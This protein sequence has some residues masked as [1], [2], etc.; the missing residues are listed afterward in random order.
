MD[1]KAK[2][3]ELVEAS[4]QDP[5]LFLVEIV[6]SN[7]NFS[8]ISII[9]DGDKG[10][11]IDDC[12]R[13]SR[14]VSE[15]LDEINFEAESYTLEVSTPG[16]DHPLKLKRQY[17][18]NIGRGFKIHRKD[19]SIIQGKL[20]HA[21]DDKIVLAEEVKEGKIIV[22]KEMILPYEEIERAFV[23]VSFK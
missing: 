16:L 4:L 9:I 13:I 2:L 20:I 5:G 23:M 19:K 12:T 3:T 17:Q 21:D 6:A 22:E 10:V 18:K 15:K 11:T 14:V 1:I 8:K 7:R